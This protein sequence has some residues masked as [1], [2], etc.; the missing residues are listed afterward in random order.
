M[1][2]FASWGWWSDH[3]SV[4]RG[5]SKMTDQFAAMPSLH[6]G[7]ALWAGWFLFRLGRRRVTRV[8]GACYPVGT[9]LVVLGTGNH[10]LLD[11]IA[12]AATMVVAAAAASWWPIRRRAHLVA[13]GAEQ[14]ARQSY[15]GCMTA[16][17]EADAPAPGSGL[18]WPLAE[19]VTR[20]RRVLRAGVRSDIPWERLPMAQVELLQRLADEPGL[21]VGDLAARHRLATNT[22]STVVQQMVQAG[23]VTRE[24]DPRDRRAVAVAPTE[25]GLRLLQ[26]WREANRRQIDAALGELPARDREA[27][28]A[29]LPALTQL[30]LRLEARADPAVQGRRP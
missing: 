3:G 30:V 13:S 24:T 26:Q 19:L 14:F 5:F 29:A 21:R 8:L 16:R 17:S 25:Q 15:S 10:Y 7:W 11:V 6:V 9:A 2:R 22:V 4:P 12:G 27:I 18:V 28:E 23:L 1:A 20:L